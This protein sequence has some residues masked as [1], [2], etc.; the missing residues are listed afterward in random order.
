MS[1]LSGAFVI[2]G[3]AA[4]AACRLLINRSLAGR[5]GNRLAR[6]P[7][8]TLLVNMAGC[9]LLGDSDIPVSSEEGMGIAHALGGTGVLSQISQDGSHIL[10]EIGGSVH[11][12]GQTC[13]AAEAN[14]IVLAAPASLPGC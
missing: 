3:A 11:P 12:E 2:L 6:F 7:A 1:A 14:H 8:A 4:G 9:F 5:P 10:A 13:L